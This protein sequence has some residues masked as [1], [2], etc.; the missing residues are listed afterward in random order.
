MINDFLLDELTVFQSIERSF[1]DIIDEDHNVSH[2]QTELNIWGY[3]SKGIRSEI[4]NWTYEVSIGFK[5]TR[6]GSR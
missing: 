4:S 1:N 2:Y 5:E 6:L 3:T